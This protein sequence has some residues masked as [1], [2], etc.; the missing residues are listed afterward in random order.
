MEFLVT[1]LSGK[2]RSNS[3]VSG[4]HKI[5][6]C[7]DIN[8]CSNHYLQAIIIILVF[9]IAV[10]L[11]FFRLMLFLKNITKSEIITIYFINLQ[12]SIDSNFVFFGIQKCLH[13]KFIIVF[14][15]VSVS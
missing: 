5:S 10:W 2:S 12:L 7:A 1:V 4:K 11:V 9:V 3:N 15:Q 14:E 13:C 6:S 8:L